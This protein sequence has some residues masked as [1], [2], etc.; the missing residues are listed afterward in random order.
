MRPSYDD[1]ATI[2]VSQSSK[3]QGTMKLMALDT[4]ERNERSRVPSWFELTEIL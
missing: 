3:I 1:Q 2:P 4:N